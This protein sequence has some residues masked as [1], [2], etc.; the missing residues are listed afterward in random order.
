MAA[1]HILY[2]RSLRPI[3]STRFQ[4][5]KR[6]DVIRQFCELHVTTTYLQRLDRFAFEVFLSVYIFSPSITRMSRFRLLTKRDP[7]LG[8][9][10]EADEGANA[11]QVDFSFTRRGKLKQ[12]RFVR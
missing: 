1:N 6:V 2:I 5:T 4:L 9:T 8:Y 11:P 12:F 10:R 3:T 7:T